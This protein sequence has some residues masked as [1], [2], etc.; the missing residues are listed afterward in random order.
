MKK[1]ITINMFGQL[2]AIDEDAYELLKNYL[3]TIRQYFRKEEGGDEIADDIEGR[4][5]ELF[6]DLK[7]QGVQAITIDHVSDIIKRIGNP[8]DMDTEEEAA[9][10][11]DG[12][13]AHGAMPSDAGQAQGQTGNAHRNILAA[14]LWLGVWDS[15]FLWCCGTVRAIGGCSATWTSS[16]FSAFQSCC[17]SCWRSSLHR[18][19]PQKSG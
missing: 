16:R 19:R 10:A 12:G 1:N 5:G 18:P 15:C 8:E 11:G 9:V 2:Y 4:I 6:S 3:D 14:T 7:R 17:I 13:T